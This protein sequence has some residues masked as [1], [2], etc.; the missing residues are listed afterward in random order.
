MNKEQ[1]E[2]I[3]DLES[4]K[5]ITGAKRFK[6]T[7]DETDR[8]LSPEEALQ[9]RL[10]ATTDSKTDGTPKKKATRRKGGDIVIRI[11]PDTTVDPDYFDDV[12]K[13][14]IVVLQDDHFYK[15]IGTLLGH[16]YKSN[17]ELYERI[18]S[19]GIGEVATDTHYKN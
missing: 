10:T 14:E 1:A 16:P 15:W 18:L 11:K 8:G 2:Q 4:Y 12:P 3:H 9:E 5:R 19:M 17:E 13:G 7:K 6:R